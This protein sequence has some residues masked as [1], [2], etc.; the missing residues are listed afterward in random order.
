MFMFVLYKLMF[1]LYKLMFGFYKLIFNLYFQTVEARY[2]LPGNEAQTDEF[3]K[4]I[5]VDEDGRIKGRLF[6]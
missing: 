1:V 6:H 4:P 3:L 5:I 2:N